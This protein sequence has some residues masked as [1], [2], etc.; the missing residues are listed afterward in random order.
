M[1]HPESAGAGTVALIGASMIALHQFASLDGAART[2]V[3]GGHYQISDA[4]TANGEN[5]HLAPMNCVNSG[6]A[7]DPPSIAA[8]RQ[9]CWHMRRAPI[10]VTMAMGE[11]EWYDG[12]NPL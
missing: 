4:R 1:E 11:S 2:A 9:S 8:N 12:G 10:F 6:A 7:N 3:P 5:W